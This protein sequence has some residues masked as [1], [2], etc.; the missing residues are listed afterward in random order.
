MAGLIFTPQYISAQLKG[1]EKLIVVIDPGHGGRDSGTIGINGIQE[2]E[3]VMKL[4]LHL[5]KINKDVF[6]NKFEIYLTRYSDTLISLSYRSK[7][8]RS[9]KADLF[10]SLHC[11]HSPVQDSRG[12]EVYVSRR[13]SINR[14][15]STYLAYRTE[16]SIAQRTGLKSRGVKFSNF[17][18]L[19]ETTDISPSVLI[20]LGFLSN[21]AEAGYLSEIR[22]FE[23]LSLA[24]LSVIN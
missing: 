18:V 19:R 15:E 4:A 1:N 5:Q 3:V 21:P 24:I 2:K 23:V 14:S 11:N 13:N 6:Q 12:T 17:E 9:L 8:A 16:K 20:E 7:I 10:I 22:N